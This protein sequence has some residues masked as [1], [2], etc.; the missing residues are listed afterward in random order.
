MG[1]HKRY[2]AR[3]LK[4]KTSSPFMFH[5]NSLFEYKRHL[6]TF[7][8][9]KPAVQSNKSAL[10]LKDC[11]NII[12]E[13]LFFFTY[14]FIEESKTRITWNQHLLSQIEKKWLWK[15]HRLKS[16]L[17]PA[18]AI[19]FEQVLSDQFF[20]FLSL[21]HLLRF[22]NYGRTLRC[23]KVRLH[24]KHTKLIDKDG[25]CLRRVPGFSKALIQF[26]T[27]SFSKNWQHLILTATQYQC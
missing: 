1:K 12:A 25:S 6:K 22:V 5:P 3:S 21:Y 7:D 14:A 9:N 2:A 26:H 27:T 13:E 8:K 20:E 16:D 10:S 11:L 15:S 17:S 19:L 18:L 24:K 4:P 23:T